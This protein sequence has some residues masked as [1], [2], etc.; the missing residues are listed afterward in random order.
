MTGLNPSDQCLLQL[1]TKRPSCAP[2]NEIQEIEC[3]N[4]IQKM[5]KMAK[6]N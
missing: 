3:K 2:A 5:Q 4:S 6:V 1:A